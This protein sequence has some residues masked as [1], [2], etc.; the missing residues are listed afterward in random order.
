MVVGHEPVP[1][2]FSHSGVMTIATHDRENRSVTA[3]VERRLLVWLAD[4]LP[5]QVSADHL[6]FLALV[7]MVTAGVG[8]ATVRFTPWSAALVVAALAVNWFGDSLDGTVARVRDQQRPRF[9]FYVDHV[10]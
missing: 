3:N 6:T 5:R 1:R 2:A 10:L 7:A 9:G 4:R 8:F